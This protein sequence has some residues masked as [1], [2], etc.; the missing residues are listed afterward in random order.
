MSS[1][2][3]ETNFHNMKRFHNNIKRDLL[4]KYVNNNDTIIDLG[5]GKGGDMHK[6]INTKVKY[7]KGYDINKEY[8]KEAESRYEKIKKQKNINTEIIYKCIDLSKKVIDTEDK[9]VNVVTCNF[10]LH[11]FFENEKTFNILKRS[12]KNNL[13]I[14]GYF[15]GT[16]FDGISVYNRFTNYE[17]TQ[18]DKLFKIENLNNNN[19]LFGNK[20]KVYLKDSIIDNIS[21][22]YLIYFGN[23][24]SKMEEEGF[25]LID[26]KLFSEIHDFNNLK[27]YEK[28]YSSLNRYF[29]FKLIN[30]N[31]NI[32][33]I[34][35]DFNSM[36]VHNL[37]DFC[38]NNSISN[39]SKFNKKEL[40]NYINDEI[41]D[42]FS[43][44][45]SLNI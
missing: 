33:N 1:S 42:K 44:K 20:I 8:L 39:Y 43:N 22:E 29:V 24:I 38:K 27:D 2:E 30:N 45:K 16:I 5:C 21:Y 28:S 4:K 9:N 13:R 37:R 32:N 26:S 31:D 25:V 3:N 40:I 34:I 17:S 36:K 15:I 18:F 35:H 12:I 11:Y 14:N 19:K 6:W 23:F 41:K 10:A 7:V